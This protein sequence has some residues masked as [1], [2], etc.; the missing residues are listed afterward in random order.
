VIFWGH[1][2]GTYTN[3]IIPWCSREPTSD[4]IPVAGDT[5]TPHFLVSEPNP[6]SNIKAVPLTYT[7]TTNTLI[8]ERSAQMA[9]N[10]PTEE[11]QSSLNGLETV[12]QN[13][14]ARE[15]Q[16]ILDDAQKGVFISYIF[17]RKRIYCIIL[18]IM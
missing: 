2:V 11:F 9:Q 14:D 7:A 1:I 16:Q 15:L 4:V 12:I 8:C 10:P 3:N 17:R 6:A 13:S 5:N 18:L